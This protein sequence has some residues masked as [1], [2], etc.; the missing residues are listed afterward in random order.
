M[1]DKLSNEDIELLITKLDELPIASF[2]VKEAGYNLLDRCFDYYDEKVE[3]TYCVSSWVERDSSG[4]DYMCLSS[5]TDVIELKVYKGRKKHE[6]DEKF[7][8][9]KL[10]SRKI[11]KLYSSLCKKL[12]KL[13]E[14]RNNAEKEKDDKVKIDLLSRIRRSTKN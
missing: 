10:K 6:P 11:A 4:P 7:P 8:D 5:S 3:L 1:K 14:E 13:C 2:D 12:E 9:L